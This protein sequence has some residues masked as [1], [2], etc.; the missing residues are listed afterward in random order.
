MGNR[1]TSFEFT[2]DANNLYWEDDYDNSLI[3]KDTESVGRIMIRKLADEGIVI[4][5]F[6]I[7]LHDKDGEGRLTVDD[8][9]NEEI[10]FDCT[11]HD[12]YHVVMTT[13]S[14]TYITKIAKVLG[15]P[16]KL[17]KTISVG[18]NKLLEREAYLIHAEDP[19]KYLYDPDEVVSLG[20]TNYLDVYDEN[21]VKWERTRNENKVKALR[22]RFAKVTPS[23]LS[24]TDRLMESDYFLILAMDD[25]N[26]LLM[27]I[28][29]GEVDRRIIT[30]DLCLMI[31]F[32][33]HMGA[34][35]HALTQEERREK[36]R[37]DDD[38]ITF[39]KKY[40]ENPEYGFLQIIITG[41][42]GT[43]K[44][45][46]GRRFKSLIAKVTDELFGLPWECYSCSESGDLISHYDG[47]EVV[48]I[49]EFRSE[50][51]SL[52]KFLKLSGGDSQ[53]VSSRYGDKFYTPRISL[54]SGNVSMEDLFEGY[55]PKDREREDPKS[56]F[57]RG[58]I[59][60]TATGE[61]GVDYDNLMQEKQIMLATY[62]SYHKDRLEEV[63][64]DLAFDDVEYNKYGIPKYVCN[65]T[66]SFDD[67]DGVIMNLLYKNM[68][69]PMLIDMINDPELSDHSELNH[70]LHNSLE[71]VKNGNYLVR[72]KVEESE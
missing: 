42:G 36:Y 61:G 4:E 67:L 29:C 23:D 25:L 41:N 68:L 46:Y 60:A 54:I 69:M 40:F 10:V 53:Y 72:G 1:A 57:R 26:R 70:Y 20:E 30:N 65:G 13:E 66:L 44:T 62:S 45:T 56:F 5:D 47:E 2:Q 43:G 51:T 35:E 31:M 37:F 33:K 16:V 34:I 50:S 63:N 3:M 18:K 52:Q 17:V 71:S 11:V 15:I 12:H 6:F 24:M 64:P 28:H 38:S 14:R 7:I 22:S 32:D 27:M 21:K 39:L 8:D 9:G 19:E 49:D 59:V 58:Q 55:G 48:R